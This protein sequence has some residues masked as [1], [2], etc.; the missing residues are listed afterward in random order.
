[1]GQPRDVL[2]R[3]RLGW[4]DDDR[5]FSHEGNSNDPSNAHIGF[6]GGVDGS[7]INAFEQSYIAGAEW[8]NSD[9]TVDVGYIG[10]YSDTDTAASIASSQYDNGADIIYHAAAAAGQGVFESAQEKNRFAIGVDADQSVT[11]EEFQDVI[12]GSAVKYINEGTREVASAVA[13]DNFE[14]VT[15]PNTLGLE[16][17][18]VDVVLG[19]AF[20]GNMPEVV[21][22]NIQD[23]KD[24][25]TSGDI[26]VP[27][28]ASG[29]N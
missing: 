26:E 19:Q 4:D 23:A 17:E 13:E 18:G 25:I 7:L 3:R 20:E 28:S 24:G 22:Q 10:D 15:G 14:S 9:V 16:E 21:S 27:C 2:P 29:C 11:L 5:S 1:V 8:V 6:V 12:I